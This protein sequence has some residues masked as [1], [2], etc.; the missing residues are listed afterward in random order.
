MEAKDTVMSNE[1]IKS[2]MLP[3]PRLETAPYM[4]AGKRILEKQA[5]ISFKA[6]YEQRQAEL[7]IEVVTK[8]EKAINIW[9]DEEILKELEDKREE[10]RK[11][12]G[13]LTY[14]CFCLTYRKPPTCKRGHVIAISLMGVLEGLL[15]SSCT[16]C[17]DFN[18]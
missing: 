14:D 15:D 18:P 8:R 12:Q 4:E 11:I 5:E 3:P 2:M 10:V 16:N 1:A 17:P 6:G 13:R 9:E 7:R